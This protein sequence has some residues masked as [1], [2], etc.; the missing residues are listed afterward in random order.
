MEGF[1]YLIH[2]FIGFQNKL[3]LCHCGKWRTLAE[4]L[5]YVWNQNKYI[6][7]LAREDKM[8]TCVLGINDPKASLDILCSNAQLFSVI[9]LTRLAQCRGDPIVLWT[10]WLL[11]SA[12]NRGV[13]PT[14]AADSMKAICYKKITLGLIVTDTIKHTLVAGRDTLH[15]PWITSSWGKNFG[16]KSI[17]QDH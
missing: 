1:I 3:L 8:T 16:D 12:C 13:S 14:A 2:V 17:W 4:D 15:W 7:I 5:L 9:P 11:S 10:G 6:G